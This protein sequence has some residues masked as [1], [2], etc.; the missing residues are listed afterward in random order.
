[1]D[2][3]IR[4]ARGVSPGL[5]VALAVLAGPATQPVLVS[6]MCLA[7]IWALGSDGNQDQGTPRDTSVQRGDSQDSCDGSPASKVIGHFHPGPGSWAPRVLGKD[8]GAFQNSMEGPSGQEGQESSCESTDS[9][10]RVWPG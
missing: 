1:M 9:G 3:S 6:T 2:H 4:P 7:L 10:C 8:L 5:V